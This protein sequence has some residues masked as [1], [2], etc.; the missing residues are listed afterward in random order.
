MYEHVNGL[1]KILVSHELQIR[2]M[3]SATIPAG[4]DTCVSSVLSGL[5]TRELACFCTEENY[6]ILFRAGNNHTKSILPY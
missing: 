3:S 5:T 4:S 2:L 1:D 6:R